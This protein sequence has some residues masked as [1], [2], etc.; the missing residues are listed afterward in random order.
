[1]HTLRVMCCS[2][3]ARAKETGWGSLKEAERK[4]EQRERREKWMQCQPFL[5]TGMGRSEFKG[6]RY[7]L[8]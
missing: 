1:M 5:R 3:V 4:G 2:A 8:I 7:H 6:V